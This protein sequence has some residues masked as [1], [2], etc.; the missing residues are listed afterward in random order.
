MTY[1]GCCNNPSQEMGGSGMDREEYAIIRLART[2]GIGNK[3]FRL[4]LQLASTATTAVE[5]FN[6]LKLKLGLKNE[7]SLIDP[8]LLDLELASIEQIGAKIITYKDEAYPKLLR[9]IYDFPLTLTYLGNIELAHRQAV[10][11][12]GSRHAS[13]NGYRYSF[14]LAKQSHL[15]NY[16]VVS[17][18]A[19]GIDAAAHKA[20]PGNTVA[21]IAGG[22]DHVYPEENRA[23]YNQIKEN[24]LILSEMP[25]GTVPKA[26][27]F[28]MRNRIISGL[29]LATIVVEAAI[30]SGSLITARFALEQNRDVYAVPSFPGDPRSRGTIKLLKEGAYLMEDFS[31][32]LN[33]NKV[34][35]QQKLTEN[36]EIEENLL[37]YTVN[38]RDIESII[39]QQIGSSET[40]IDEVMTN[41]G[42]NPA[43]VLSVITKLELEGKLMRCSYNKVVKMVL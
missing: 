12:V 9:E 15:A 3:T 2:R 19:Y 35:K 4:L 22:I 28:P 26:T 7:I 41:T 23:L 39:L 31:D 11:I 24:G 42:F 38:N 17:G 10:A 27:N 20:E 33:Q 13:A 34:F 1:L 43:E 37:T 16:V 29:S 14:N 6:D 18:L 30:N 36:N 40:L 25:F 5:N 8:K 32:F 21:C